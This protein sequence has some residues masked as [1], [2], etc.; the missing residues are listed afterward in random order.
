MLGQP[1][2][3][4]DTVNQ[5]LHRP[6]RI[7]SRHSLHIRATS[8]CHMSHANQVYKIKPS[9]KS[10]LDKIRCL[11]PNIRSLVNSIVSFCIVTSQHSLEQSLYWLQREIERHTGSEV[12]QLRL[13]SRKV[14]FRLCSSRRSRLHSQGDNKS[15][16]SQ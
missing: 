1:I 3:P 11:L 15:P 2:R 9:L 7:L 14:S 6:I 16:Q 13:S 10:Q 12:S 8:Q 5:G 4:L